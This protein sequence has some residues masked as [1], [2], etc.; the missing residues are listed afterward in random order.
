MQNSVVSH[1]FPVAVALL[2]LALAVAPA[3]AAAA[4]FD[5][6]LDDAVAA[7]GRE[8]YEDGLRLLDEAARLRQDP[9]IVYYRGYAFEKL[10]RCRD[11]KQNYEEVA[12]DT[13][14]SEKLRSIAVDALSGVVDRCA[15]PT[16]AIAARP[17][18]E[19]TADTAERGLGEGRTGWKMLATSFVS[20]GAVALVS[21]PLQ[22]K[23]IRR[24][25]EQGQ[26]YF[27]ARYG[28]TVEY[29]KVSGEACDAEALFEDEAYD[30]YQDTLAASR[31]TVYAVA[32]VGV[33]L[34]GAGIVT[35]LTVGLSRPST[36]TAVNIGVG[37]AGVSA[38][39]RF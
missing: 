27:E 4:P 1:P 7:L 18:V 3:E 12:R 17:E 14:G 23:A 15:Q 31:R 38:A 9:R 8:D 34:L 32:S 13:R 28:C 2:V 30:R 25:A 36:S 5:Q 10:G 11:A 21:V 6:L 33:G 26:P 20:I 37:P 22:A 29:G 35:F 19:A 39:F 24:L 16:P